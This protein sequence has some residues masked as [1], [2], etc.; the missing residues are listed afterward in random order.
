MGVEGNNGP[1][2]D[3]ASETD[4]GSINAPKDDEAY[5]SEYS[6]YS[7]IIPISLPSE[8]TNTKSK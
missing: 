1:K 5:E 7:D 4:I 2:D 6:Q 3:E 8:C